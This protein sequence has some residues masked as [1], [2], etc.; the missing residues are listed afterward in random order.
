MARTYRAGAGQVVASRAMALDPA[1]VADCPYGPDA[2][3]IDEILEID[4]EASRVRARMPA[5]ADL[6]ITRDQ[7]AHPVR[8]PR[9]VSGALMIHATGIMG[10]AHAYYVL[11]LRH[12]EGWIGYGTHIHDGRFRRMA[13]MG[14]PLVLDCQATRVRKIGG[15]LVGRY[16]FVF[17]QDGASVYEA[18][19]SSLFTQVKEASG[20]P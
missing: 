16:K 13:A 15:A 3:L 12:T 10:F 1:F 6:P 14:T 4:A 5:H 17:T 7:R 11:G 19:H 18:E 9:H 8:H 20:T 2:L